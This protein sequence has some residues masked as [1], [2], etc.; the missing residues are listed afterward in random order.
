MALHD[1]GRS[2]AQAMFVDLWK[3]THKVL[4][5]VVKH[6]AVEMTLKKVTLV[7]NEESVRLL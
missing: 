3:P 6:S 2:Q 1:G 5:T 7:L 4:G